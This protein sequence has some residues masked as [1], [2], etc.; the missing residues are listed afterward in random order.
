MNYLLFV[1]TQDATAVDAQQGAAFLNGEISANYI[2]ESSEGVTFSYQIASKPRLGSNATLDIGFSAKNPNLQNATTSVN[3][4]L[5]VKEDEDG[6]RKGFTYYFNP[7]VAIENIYAT[8]DLNFYCKASKGANS[9]SITFSAH[10]LLSPFTSYEFK[11]PG[12]RNFEQF[13]KEIRGLKPDN[14]VLDDQKQ[15][16]IPIPSDCVTLSLQ[17]SDATIWVDYN[18]VSFGS[19][20][21]ARFKVASP[22]VRLAT[23]TNSNMGGSKIIELITFG[24][25]TSTATKAAASQ[26]TKATVSASAKATATSAKT[27]KEGSI[28]TS[29]GKITKV[30][31]QSLVCAKIGSKLLWVS[32]SGSSS[33]ES[34]TSSPSPSKKCTVSSN[35]LKSSVG[36]DTSQGFSMAALVFENLSDCNLSIAA[37]ASFICP[38]GGA[39]KPTN[40]VQSTGN[41]TLAPRQKLLMSSLRAIDRYFPL[42]SQ[43]CFQLTGFK[44]N[45]VHI[46]TLYGGKIKST[47]LTSTP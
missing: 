5:S 22:S 8:L 27:V 39:L 17:R 44:S 31:T 25:T 2:W 18:N 34:T 24:S 33:S 15:I 38:D 4:S 28:C 16:A 37:V 6:E 47:V 41:F 1:N 19:F 23:S 12:T 7:G 13:N 3:R 29:A 36:S 14:L 46:D 35:L 32:L 40:L 11:S 9:K 45:T 43:Q 30:S 21:G 10:R 26:S 20:S 42:L